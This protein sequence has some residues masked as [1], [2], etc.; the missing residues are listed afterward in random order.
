MNTNGYYIKY[1]DGTMICTKK[2]TISATQSEWVA[3]GSCYE[4]PVKDCGAW[5]QSFYST[6]IIN[7]TSTG[8]AGW[9][10]YFFDTSATNVG[11]TRMVRPTIPGAEVS[12]YLNIVGIG[13]WKA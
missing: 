10:E 13:R 8:S 1:P 6:P 2:V 5:A 9:L 12:Y 7:V 11:K 3:W 4:T